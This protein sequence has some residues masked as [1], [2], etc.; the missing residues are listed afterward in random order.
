MNSSRGCFALLESFCPVL[1]LSSAP[2][3]FWIWRENIFSVSYRDCA[4]SVNVDVEHGSIKG[5]EI[6]DR[7]G[8]LEVLSV[9]FCTFLSSSCLFFSN[10]VRQCF[11]TFFF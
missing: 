6:L 3:L 9:L 4:L 5:Y 11:P 8:V 2:H 7:N 10:E 1:V